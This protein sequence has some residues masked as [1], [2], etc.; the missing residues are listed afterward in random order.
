MEK[1]QS[2]LQEQ[3]YGIG[4][5]K[6][7]LSN[8]VSFVTSFRDDLSICKS[9]FLILYFCKLE[10]AWRQASMRSAVPGS[11]RER[12]RPSLAVATVFD[13]QQEIGDKH[14]LAI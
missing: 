4:L 3:G 14:A 10:T 9:D 7:G 6:T 8:R 12:R 1:Q 13:K 2:S 5:G 11:S